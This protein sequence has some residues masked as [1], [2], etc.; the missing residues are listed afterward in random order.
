SGSGGGFSRVFSAPAYQATSVSGARGIPDVAYDADP[1]SGFSVY[2]SVP[3][4]SGQAGWMVVGGT[5]AGAPQ[6][7]GLIAL[8]DQERAARGRPALG[9]APTHT[10]PLPGRDSHD[11]PGGGKGSPAG[12]G[13]DLETGRGTP[14]PAL[15]AP[16]RPGAPPPVTPTPPAPN[17]PPSG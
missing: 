13:Y 6:W 3:D 10:S 11:I 1:Q 17:S 4:S 9:G 16:D 12:P 14:I 5:S 2:S 7:A 15:L 8:A